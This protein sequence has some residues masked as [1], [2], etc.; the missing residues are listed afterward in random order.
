MKELG[1]SQNNIS[2]SIFFELNHDHCLMS[3]QR[4]TEQH[5]SHLTIDWHQLCV[6]YI[7]IYTNTFSPFSLSFLRETNYGSLAR[8]CNFVEDAS[9]VV[10]KLK[11]KLHFCTQRPLV[12]IYA[13]LKTFC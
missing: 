12:L 11:K 2:K 7:Y 13:K 10:F 9:I 8:G 1:S 6:C 5:K 3:L 4:D